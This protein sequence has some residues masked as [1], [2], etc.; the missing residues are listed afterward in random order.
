MYLFN[1]FILLYNT[2]KLLWCYS[3]KK[4]GKDQGIKFL[5]RV[6]NLQ[7]IKYCITTHIW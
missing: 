4:F 3:L 7:A 5:K 2:P 1:Y 6:F